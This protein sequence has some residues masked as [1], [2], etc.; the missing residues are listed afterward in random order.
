V[1]IILTM[2]IVLYWRG[3]VDAKFHHL[4]HRWGIGQKL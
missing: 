4:V 3:K 2:L 1:E